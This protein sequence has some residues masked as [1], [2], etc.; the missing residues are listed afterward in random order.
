MNI[1]S[2]GRVNI[3]TQD[4]DSN[5]FFEQLVVD[6]EPSEGSGETAAIGAFGGAPTGV[7]DANGSTGIYAVGGDGAGNA[8]ADFAGDW[9]RFLRRIHSGEQQR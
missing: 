7:T 9:R 1:G 3:G 2:N 4:T 6:S 5:D 8:Q